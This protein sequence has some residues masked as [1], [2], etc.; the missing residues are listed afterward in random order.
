[1]QLLQGD[2]REVIFHVIVCPGKLLF[3][4]LCMY[5]FDKLCILLLEH[6]GIVTLIKL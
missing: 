5:V 1:M 4:Q 3:S 6:L 2:L